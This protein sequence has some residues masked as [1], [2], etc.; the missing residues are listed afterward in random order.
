MG[1]DKEPKFEHVESSHMA[2]I[3]KGTGVIALGAD[4]PRRLVMG[5]ALCPTFLVACGYRMAG[6]NYGLASE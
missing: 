5:G 6:M 2:A 3:A 1:L 4:M